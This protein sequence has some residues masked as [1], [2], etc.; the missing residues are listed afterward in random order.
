MQRRSDTASLLPGVAQVLEPPV[1][2][3][4]NLAVAVHELPGETLDLGYRT[5]PEAELGIT[6]EH[7][8]QSGSIALE[9]A[10]SSH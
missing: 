6:G 2:N 1:M 4:D 10:A 3:D 9:I 7:L 5:L 8:L